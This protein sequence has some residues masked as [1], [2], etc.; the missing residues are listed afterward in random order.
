VNVILAVIS[1]FLPV[2]GQ[3]LY[4]AESKTEEAQIGRKIYEESTT[5]VTPKEQLDEAMKIFWT[6]NVGN[7][8]MPTWAMCN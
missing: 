8:Y 2:T 3:A 7:A 1:R 4:C 5:V 6:T